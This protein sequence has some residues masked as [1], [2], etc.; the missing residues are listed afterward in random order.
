M[1][2]FCKSG[3]FS[4]VEHREDASLVMVRARFRGDLERFLKTHK[5]KAK[6]ACTPGADYKYRITIKK[7]EWSKAVSSEAEA[8][9]YD[10]FKSSVHDGSGRDAAYLRCWAALR[11]AQ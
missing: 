11:T 5:I 6:V 4:A 3:F 8:I 9:D 1:W 10:N 7:D 2:V